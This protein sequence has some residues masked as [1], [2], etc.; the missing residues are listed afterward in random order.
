MT[1]IQGQQARGARG[2]Y[3]GSTQT[4]EGRIK[5]LKRF[6]MIA[7]TLKDCEVFQRIN[8]PK[9]IEL[10]SNTDYL[11]FETICEL[12]KFLSLLVKGVVY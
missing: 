9:T 12:K 8:T 4:S 11:C 6:L 10:L 7:V 3:L 1:N 5:V 2:N